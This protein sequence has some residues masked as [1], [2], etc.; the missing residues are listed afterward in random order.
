VTLIG[1]ASLGPGF[2]QAYSFLTNKLYRSLQTQ[3]HNE[4]M[5]S[6]S[7]RS[8]EHAGEVKRVAPRD[9]C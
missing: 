8:G 2:S 9:V 6:C 4:T 3:V 7:G 1:E 5:G